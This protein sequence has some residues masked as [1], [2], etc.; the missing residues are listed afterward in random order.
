MKDFKLMTKIAA[1]LHYTSCEQLIDMLNLTKGDRTLAWKVLPSV[2]LG[3]MPR[4]LLSSMN[5]LVTYDVCVKLAEMGRYGEVA[6]SKDRYDM[7]M[8]AWKYTN[9]KK[10]EMRAEMYD[11]VYNIFGI[12]VA[13]SALL[14]TKDR[15]AKTW[16][17]IK[18]G[19]DLFVPG[20]GSFDLKHDAFRNEFERSYRVS[21]VGE[22]R[23]LGYF[24]D[25]NWSATRILQNEHGTRWLARWYQVIKAEYENRLDEFIGNHG[26][27]TACFDPANLEVHPRTMLR[28]QQQA[29]VQKKLDDDE[30]YKV[31][32]ESMKKLPDVPVGDAVLRVMRS[33]MMLDMAARGLHNCAASYASRVDKGKCIVAVL[34]QADRPLAMGELVDGAWRQIVGP[35]NRTPGREI[36][37]LFENNTGAFT[38]QKGK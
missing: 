9:V 12:K 31:E 22:I 26:E 37:E 24:G 20:M 13:S 29:V 8:L 3:P 14:W 35:C 21:N 27:P 10:Y 28:L 6:Y 38:A 7:A 16:K 11:N 34:E 19:R 25:R 15:D 36:I 23:G 18:R 5:H 17:G 4:V 30:N 33:P 1:S 32:F 2:K